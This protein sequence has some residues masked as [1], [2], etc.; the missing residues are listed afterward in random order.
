MKSVSPVCRVAASGVPS[1]RFYFDQ[2]FISYLCWKMVVVVVVVLYMGSLKH[3]TRFDQSSRPIEGLFLL[4][5]ILQI[6]GLYLSDFSREVTTH[7]WLS[8]DFNEVASG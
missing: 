1:E 6:R 7:V 2:L 5:L 8:L 4:S 3:V